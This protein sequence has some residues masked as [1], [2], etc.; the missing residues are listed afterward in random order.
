M[1]I[2]IENLT[3]EK[4]GL[5]LAHCTEVLEFIRKKTKLEMVVIFN[6]STWVRKFGI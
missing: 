4:D 2:K 1:N 3:L 5:G 6:F